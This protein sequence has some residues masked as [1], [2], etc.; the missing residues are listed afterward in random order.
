MKYIWLFP[1]KH[2]PEPVWALSMAE[3]LE[4]FVC[5]ELDSIPCPD[6]NSDYASWKSEAQ[7]YVSH[8]PSTSND[9]LSCSIIIGGE[10][11]NEK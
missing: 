11:L 6:D 9:G 1:D 7:K 10:T 3:S 5:S 8:D 2:W 4:C